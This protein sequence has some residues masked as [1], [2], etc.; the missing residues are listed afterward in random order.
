MSDTETHGDMETI[1]IE[2]ACA[3]PDRQ[4]ILS[5][6]VAQG[7]TALQAV[8]LSGMAQYFPELALAQATL[9]IY[10]QILGTRGLAPASQYV[11]KAGDRVEIYR[12]LRVDPKE[13][14]RKRASRTEGDAEGE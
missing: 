11:L 9:G 1:A 5:L 4:K 14:R 10:G 12:P 7:T 2:V 3:L 6:Q 8:Q 13:A